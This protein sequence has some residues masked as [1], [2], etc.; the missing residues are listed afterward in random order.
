MARQRRQGNG[1]PL[2]LATYLFVQAC[3]AFG[4][5]EITAFIS[6][7]P[8]SAMPSTLAPDRLGAKQLRKIN[9]TT[10]F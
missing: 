3:R 5:L 10:P 6:S 8:E 2:H 7:S 1:D 4:L 9:L